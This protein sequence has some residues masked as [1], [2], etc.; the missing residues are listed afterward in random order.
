MQATSQNTL[1]P[2]GV[3]DGVFLRDMESLY[4]EKGGQQSIR[5]PLC[6]S[7][8]IE[9]LT[10]LDFQINE[11]TITRLLE[12]QGGVPTDWRIGDVRR[13]HALLS[14]GQY[15]KPFPSLWDAA[16]PSGRVA[17]EAGIYLR[18]IT[19]PTERAQAINRIKPEVM[20]CLLAA[21]TDREDQ[22]VLLEASLFRFG[23]LQT[24][25]R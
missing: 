25:G 11:E 22:M 20:L 3:S 4:R 13:L 7:E 8:V 23:L 21:A 24:Q 15:F 9:I 6:T 2:A 18:R 16:K 1:N 14:A 17:C 19:E 5:F 10:T 12:S